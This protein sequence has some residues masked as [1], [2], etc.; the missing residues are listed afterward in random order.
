MLPPD[1]LI[2]PFKAMVVPTVLDTVK[3]LLKVPEPFIVK[4]LEP[5]MAAAAV[6]EKLLVIVKLELV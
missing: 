4:L 1:P 5:P 6:T 2:T 3:A